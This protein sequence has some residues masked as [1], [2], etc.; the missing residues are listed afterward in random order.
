M[1][2]RFWIVAAVL[3]TGCPE[4][5]FVE[6]P[7]QEVCLDRSDGARYCIDVYEASR[8]D[9]DRTTAGVDDEGRPRS[10]PDRLPWTDIT[11]SGARTA[12][13][14]VGKRLCALDE[15][16]DACDGVPG[17]GGNKYTY[18]DTLDATRCNTMNSGV[19]PSGERETCKSLAN[20]YDQSG[21]VYEW[22]GAS[23]GAAAARGGGPQSS[24]TH[25]CDDALP[26]A[27]PNQAN[28]EIGF[29][30]CRDT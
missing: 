19:E 23:M 29:R 27:P 22:T 12:C 16:V 24:Q 3:L 7:D 5:P 30:C 2:S 17:D 6:V 11:W 9:A 14:R 26:G 15:W 4:E 1:S 21:N 28:T 20:T 10:L 18:G 8:E 25:A 13:E